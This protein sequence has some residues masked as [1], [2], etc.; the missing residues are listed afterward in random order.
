MW[1]SA[2]ILNFHHTF[3]QGVHAS[4]CDRSHVCARACA[5]VHR[6]VHFLWRVLREDMHGQRARAGEVGGGCGGCGRGVPV[7]GVTERPTA[8]D[9]SRP[10][11]SQSFPT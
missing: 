6:F 4:L 7:G 11:V 3:L 10:P 2:I 1:I 9:N 8:L 5:C